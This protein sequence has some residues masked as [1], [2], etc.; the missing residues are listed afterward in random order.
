MLTY[1]QLLKMTKKMKTPNCTKN[2]IVHMN[3]KSAAPSV[4][5]APE[6]TEMP[7]CGHNSR[8]HSDDS[9]P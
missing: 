2:F 9:H 8:K 6:R 3:R 5:I 1:T 7:T 4:L